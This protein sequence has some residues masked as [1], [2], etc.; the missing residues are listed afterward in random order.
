MKPLKTK[1]CH[2][3]G[4]S[5]TLPD[6]NAGRLLRTER[7]RAGVRVSALADAMNISDSYL[8]DLERGHR[9]LTNELL[10]AYQRGLEKLQC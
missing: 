4:G 8:Y 5:G 7:E 2:A 10:G 3:C 1:C 9:K 6:G